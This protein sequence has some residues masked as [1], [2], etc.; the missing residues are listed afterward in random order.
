MY[1]QMEMGIEEAY[2]WGKK[3]CAA[4]VFSLVIFYILVLGNGD[5]VERKIVNYV[6]EI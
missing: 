5:I 2:R 3:I 6:A 1:E 4:C